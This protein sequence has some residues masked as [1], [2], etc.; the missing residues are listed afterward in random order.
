MEQEHGDEPAQALARVFIEFGVAHPEILTPP[1]ACPDTLRVPVLAM[2]I[3]ALLRPAVEQMPP[4]ADAKRGLPRSREQT[5][6]RQPI[7]RPEILLEE[8]GK[9]YAPNEPHGNAAFRA[10]RHRV[11]DRVASYYFALQR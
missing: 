7:G 9:W 4:S 11:R 6:C 2:L 3:F 10:W 1:L 5:D 8:T